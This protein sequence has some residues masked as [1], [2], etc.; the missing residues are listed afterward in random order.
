MAGLVLSFGA[1]FLGCWLMFGGFGWKDVASPPRLQGGLFWGPPISKCC[2]SQ[3]GASVVLKGARGEKPLVPSTGTGT[4]DGDV[5]APR[6][7]CR[8]G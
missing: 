2:D 7:R 1:L 5:A 6:P 3:R 8:W 4:W